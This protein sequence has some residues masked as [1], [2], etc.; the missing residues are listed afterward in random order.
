VAPVASSDRPYVPRRRIV[1]QGCPHG[2][3]TKHI[4]RVW[5][6]NLCLGR[7]RCDII[8]SQPSKLL[9][10]TF[11]GVQ[12]GGITS[13]DG[14]SSWVA[15][16][17]GGFHVTRELD[18]WSRVRLGPLLQ[19]RRDRSGTVT[20]GDDSG[21]I[22]PRKSP[23]R[24]CVPGMPQFGSWLQRTGRASLVRHVILRVGIRA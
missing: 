5:G 19:S 4:Y 20:H 23:R 15:R 13:G 18:A 14:S 24:A 6:V 7:V 2:S 16:V 1:S 21:L 12:S 8:V 11:A 10:T 17:E 9:R 22:V 3:G